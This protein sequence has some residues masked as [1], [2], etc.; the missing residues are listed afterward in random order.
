MASTKIRCGVAGTGSLG[1]HHARIYASL[2]GAELAGIY[3]TDDARAAEICA[4]H[5]CRRFPML[6]ELGAACDAVSVVVPTDRHA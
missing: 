2:P 3:E 1:Q 6:A 5:G 4:R